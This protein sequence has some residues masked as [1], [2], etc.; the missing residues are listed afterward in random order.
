MNIY[1]ELNECIRYIED[2]LDDEID[3]KYISKIFGC[4]ESTIQRVFSLIT[5]MTLTEY[6]RRR[7]LTVA[8]SDIKNNEK[9]IDIAI[10]YGYSSDVSFSRSFKRMHN[11]LPSR[12]KKSNV[13]LNMQPILK[14]NENANNNHLSYR[15]EDLN[16]FT[17][18][19]IKREVDINNI[20]NIAEKLWKY[21]KKTYSKF[22]NGVIFGV[23]KQ[24]DEKFYYYCAIEEKIDG[25]EKIDIPKSKWIVFKN[26]ENNDGNKIKKLFNDALDMYIP[27]IGFKSN[28]S[29]ELEKYNSDYMEIYIMIN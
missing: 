28:Q 4:S 6:I 25:F 27:S 15:I 12:V 26:N 7:R 20:P 1:K 16:K 23:I 22:N 5:G 11:I 8:I 19:G 14:F 17:L 13:K 18:Y 10:K 2:N 21:V 24:I 9:I 29:F 3:Y